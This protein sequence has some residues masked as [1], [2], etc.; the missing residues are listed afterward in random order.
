MIFDR[1]FQRLPLHLDG[2]FIKS[3]GDL[4][5]PKNWDELITISEKLAFGFKYVRVD[6]YNVNNRII[7]GELTFFPMS[8]CYVSPDLSS[9]GDLIDFDFYTYKLPISAMSALPTVEGS[10]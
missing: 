5:R 9:F 8:G 2:D 3:D 10:L 6:L 1:D 4:L 7:F